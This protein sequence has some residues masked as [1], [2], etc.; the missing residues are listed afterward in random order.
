[1]T[2]S[3]LAERLDELSRQLV[4]GCGDS[5][6]VILRPRGLSTN[7]GCRCAPRNFARNLRSIYE[8]LQEAGLHGWPQEEDQ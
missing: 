2:R 8:R 7:G 5:G 3:E 1:M 4:N 6:C